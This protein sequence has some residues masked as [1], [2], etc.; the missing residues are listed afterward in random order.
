VR[1][2]ELR[3]DRVEHGVAVVAFGQMVES[4]VHKVGG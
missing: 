2:I 1:E 4:E 3:G